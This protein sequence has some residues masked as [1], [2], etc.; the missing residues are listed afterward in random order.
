MNELEMKIQRL[1]QELGMWKNR[2]VEAAQVACD[3]CEEYQED[4]KKCG[5]CRIKRIKEEAAK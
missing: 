5:N 3:N 4:R 1:T 2:A